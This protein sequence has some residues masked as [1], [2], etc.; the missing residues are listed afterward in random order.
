MPLFAASGV[1]VKKQATLA[2][3]LTPENVEAQGIALAGHLIVA[4]GDIVKN[5][6]VEVKI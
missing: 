4:N 2:A 1:T 5:V 3:I 6:E